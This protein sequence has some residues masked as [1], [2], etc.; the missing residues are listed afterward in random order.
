MKGPASNWGHP[1]AYHPTLAHFFGSVNAALFFGQLRYWD[2]RTENPLGVY[3]TSEEWAEETGLS[4]REQTTARRILVDAQY[5][6]ETNKRLEHR[7]YFKI[8][9]DAFNPDFEAWISVNRPATKALAPN[10]G[11]RN[12]PND[13]NAIRGVL[14]AQP[15]Y[16]TETT[17]ETTA[18]TCARSGADAPLSSAKL[19]SCPHSVLIDLFGKHLP[20]MPQPKPEL[21]TGA[22]ATATAARWKWVLTATKKSGARYAETREDALSFFERFFAYVSKSDFLTGR[23][24]KWTRCNLA[25]LM[26]ADNFAKVLEGHYEN[27]SAA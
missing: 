9:W 15:V 16:K 10:C 13:E 5:V 7:L 22:K 25:W 8:D 26:K 18:E 2:E 12:S 24:E 19:P 17:A 21:W 6:I 4:Y 14:K 20:S 1:V 23:N 27:E 11:K 3:K